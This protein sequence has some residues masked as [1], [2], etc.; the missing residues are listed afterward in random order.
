M[1]LIE[2][3]I[4]SKEESDFIYEI[5]K[6]I[7]H[8]SN[9]LKDVL[10]SAKLYSRELPIELLN[11]INNFLLKEE[12][13]GIVIKNNK[14]LDKNIGQT[15]N[16]HFLREEK[17]ICSIEEILFLLYSEYIGYAFGW[18][19]IQN[20]NLINEIVPIE[21]QKETLGSAG[22][23][24]YFDLHTEDAFSIY[25]GEYLG[26]LGM[27][28]RG[29]VETTIS[30]IKKDD[31]SDD[32]R[33]ILF[34]KNFLIGRNT[35]HKVK[36]EYL[37]SSILYGNRKNPY[38][39]INANNTIALNIESQ[40]TLEKLRLIL[41]RN[42]IG[43]SIQQGDLFLLDNLRAA[44]GRNSYEPLYDGMDRWLKRLYITL[45]LKR[46]ASIR[47]EVESRILISNSDLG[48]YD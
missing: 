44:H 10:Y 34:A 22:S 30:Y 41:N 1:N 43:Y 18:N 17:Q 36:D 27:R 35:N 26:L 11:F 13:L 6:K 8:K 45:D 7:H 23:D 40:Q 25:R 21:A 4:L 37:P 19:S 15:P 32:E 47:N 12:Y 28:D 38:F 42:T 20:G 46:S 3:Y 24:I 29:E 31:L 33:N 48:N 9:N 2:T 16:R 5:A 39:V 14:I